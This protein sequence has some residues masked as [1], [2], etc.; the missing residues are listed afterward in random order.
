M[1]TFIKWMGNKSKHLNKIIKYIPE[2]Y[3]TYIEPFVGSGVMFLKLEPEKWIIN[4]INKDLINIWKCVKK[5][6][7]NIIENFKE[8]G[9]IFKR[10]STENKKKYCKEI[11]SKLDKMSYDIDRASTYMLMTSCAY[12]GTIL[13]NNEFKFNGLDMNIYVNNRYSFLN[14]NIHDNLKYVSE[15]L[16]DST[17]KIYN[18]DYKYILEKAKKGDFVFLYPPYI[19]EHDYH[20]KYNKDEVLDNKFLKD[21]VKELKKL[22]KKDVKWLMTQADTKE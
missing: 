20:F 21:L 3:N 17:G 6:P 11:V 2:D 12:M 22:D 10:K 7:D 14:N 13:I 8:F 5:N 16:N 9:Q 19:E 18:K 1:R 15:Y 4:D